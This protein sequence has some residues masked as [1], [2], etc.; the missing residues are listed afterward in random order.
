MELTPARSSSRDSAFTD[1]PLAAG[2]TPIKA[3]HIA[4]LRARIDAVRAARGLGAYSLYTDPTLIPGSTVIKAV[5]ITDLRTALNQAYAA[6]V[7]PLPPPVYTDP[8]LGAGMPIRL[9]QIAE[10]RSAVIAIE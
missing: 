3:V 9:V 7:P 4:E 10:I 6:N 2:V 5:H 8:S 1:D